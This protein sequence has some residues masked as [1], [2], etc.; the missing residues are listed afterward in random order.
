MNSKIG[1]L[2]VKLKAYL[3]TI[4]VLVIS[5]F[6]YIFTLYS[7]AT[8]AKIL[9]VI[10]LGMIPACLI[11]VLWEISIKHA[12]IQ[13][14]QREVYLSNQFDKFGIRDIFPSR[15]E[16]NFLNYIQTAKRRIWILVTSF[17]YLTETP[18]IHDELIRKAKEGVDL[19]VLGLNPNS[20]SAKL[21][22]AFNPMYKN[23]KQEIPF[24]GERFISGF[25]KDRKNVPKVQIRLYDKIPTYACFIVDNQLF[26]C[27][28]LCH[29][30]GRN[31]VH[32]LVS[33]S[34]NRGESNQ[35]FEEYESH[36]LELFKNASEK[37]D[38]LLTKK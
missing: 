38:A 25:E 32:F 2:V 23:L 22:S 8:Y 7:S 1:W 21:R 15:G 14:I 11:G 34:T 17:S 13:Y 26:L 19:R 27:P 33:K 35:L 31:S 16:I 12:F 30:R 4:S 6:M 3:I 10:A 24:F 28:L 37:E 18:G 36:F 29:K 5:I 9:N 20:E